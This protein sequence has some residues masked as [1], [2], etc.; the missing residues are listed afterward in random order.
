M[1]S[2]QEDVLGDLGFDGPDWLSN[3]TINKRW[4]KI[5]PHYRTLGNAAEVF[6][7][8]SAESFTGWKKDT[9]KIGEGCKLTANG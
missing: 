5:L 1:R 2:T 8:Q 9:L 3:A 6:F 7:E 4:W